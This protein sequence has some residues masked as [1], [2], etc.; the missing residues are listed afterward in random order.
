MGFLTLCNYFWSLTVGFGF[1]LAST[2]DTLYYS[3]TVHNHKANSTDHDQ[4]APLKEQS[5]HGLYCLPQYLSINNS[6]SKAFEHFPYIRDI[7]AQETKLPMIFTCLCINIYS[8][9]LTD[10][11]LFSTILTQAF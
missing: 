11:L 2:F 7:L 6:F 1:N 3:V 5:D 10:M 9:E 4:T 8:Y